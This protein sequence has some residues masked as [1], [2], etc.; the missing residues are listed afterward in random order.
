MYDNFVN[1]W[2]NRLCAV[3]W[4]QSIGIVVTSRWGKNMRDCDV[5]MKFIHLYQVMW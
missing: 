3:S 2:T 5:S 4:P 1:S